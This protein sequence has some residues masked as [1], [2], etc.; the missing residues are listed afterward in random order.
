MTGAFRGHRDHDTVDALKPPF[1]LLLGPPPVFFAAH[2]EVRPM[3]RR[4][5][6]HFQYS[7]GTQQMY[8]I[9]GSLSV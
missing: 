8:P 6:S 3:I 1:R 2:A 7:N 9:V 5:A 4:G